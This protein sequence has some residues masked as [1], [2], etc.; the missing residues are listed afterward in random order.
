MKT[1][2]N[3]YKIPSYYISKVLLQSAGKLVALENENFLVILMKYAWKISSLILHR[4]KKVIAKLRVV[5]RFGKY[6]VYLNSKHGSLYVC[7]YLKASVLAI[8]KAIAGKPMKSLREIEPDLALPR[9]SSSGLPS[10]IGTRDRR[11]IKSGSLSVVQFYL[12]LFSVYR[13]IESPVKAKLETITD[14]F[15]GSTDFL[16]G[17]LGWFERNFKQL[18]RNPQKFH[19]KGKLGREAGLMLLQTSSPTQK[20]HSWRG[21]AYDAFLIRKSPG[22]YALFIEWLTLTENYELKRILQLSK[23]VR[24]KESE[25]TY[26]CLKTKRLYSNIDSLGELLPVE[27]QVRWK[28]SINKNILTIKVYDPK[29]ALDKIVNIRKFKIIDSPG[30]QGCRSTKDDVPCLG[31][32]SF[33]V[34]A[35]G[36]LRVFAMVDSWTQSIFKPLHDSLFSL[37][38]TIPNDATFDQDLAFKRAIS[39][40]KES[41]HCYGFDLS[42]ATD[43]LP[44]IIQ[45]KILSG[46]IGGH[47]ASLWGVILSSRDFYI[48]EN[49]YI[50]GDYF[51]RYAVGQPMGALS[52][53]AMLALTHHA[54]VQYANSLIGNRGWTE[55][56]EV[57]GDDIVIFDAHLASKYVEL[58]GEFGVALNMSKSV[59]SIQKEPVVE[60]AKK[61]SL[62]GKDV[63]P[64]SLKMFLNQDSFHGKIS[65]F[66]YWSRKINSHYLF[67]FK[68][69]MKSYKWDNRAGKDIFSALALISL[70]VKKGIIPFEWV[71][72]EIKDSRGLIIRKGKMLL[73]NVPTTWLFQVSKAILHGEDLLNYEPRNSNSYMFEQRWY[74][75]A[76]IQRIQR[77]CQQYDYTDVHKFRMNILDD[78]GLVGN[79]GIFVKHLYYS[80]FDDHLANA[81]ITL[82]FYSRL[83]LADYSL[84]MLLEFVEKVEGAASIIG[85]F[86][87]KQKPASILQDSMRIL[88]W[89]SKV[90][91]DDFR[92]KV[93]NQKLALESSWT[94]IT[95]KWDPDSNPLHGLVPGF[96]GLTPTSQPVSAL[97]TDLVFTKKLPNTN[98]LVS[99]PTGPLPESS[100]YRETFNPAY[101]YSREQ[102]LEMMGKT[103]KVTQFPMREFKA[104]IKEFV[105][106]FC[107]GLVILF[108]QEFLIWE[109]KPV[110]SIISN[111]NDWDYPPTLLEEVKVWDFSKF[112]WLFGILLL[113][114]ISFALGYIISPVIL[115]VD[116]YQQYNL[117][118]ELIRPLIMPSEY[119]LDWDE[120]RSMY[121]EGNLYEVIPTPNIRSPEIAHGWSEPYD[122]LNLNSQ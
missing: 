52:S 88:Q 37:L 75:V 9:L 114:C 8:Q 100:R 13:I 10:I 101:L 95:E 92:K 86:S 6:L 34:E 80:K 115:E 4:D 74:K 103:T 83:K 91:V 67:A 42:A 46:F 2:K 28:T 64:L 30:I 65:I 69:I 82:R 7:K 60:F 110:Y 29:S 122:P 56:Y 11:A 5:Y 77:L 45:I 38:K 1:R 79:T 97:D 50:P 25:R 70:Y 57:L 98:W 54:I 104:W 18:I 27:E 12:S 112:Y 73:A 43:R 55:A 33:K 113:C 72:R 84:A 118:S 3:L 111:K 49:K 59:I 31:R 66:D 90:L 61:T 36:K 62:K 68:T 16:E 94:K 87:R 116:D 39:K 22:L 40:S 19:L 71:L 102:G 24:P 107:I 32:L 93:E 117:T 20:L 89:I 53:W 121:R 44:L 85:T 47:L 119:N 21:W 109:A 48:P 58:M 23:N 76:V 26:K 41:G 51:I 35:A 14:P 78:L 108:C 81:F 120:F 15:S 96:P 17:S 63:S 99:G 106:Y 105:L